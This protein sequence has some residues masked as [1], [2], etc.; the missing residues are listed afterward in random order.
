MGG[1][2][3]APE[4]ATPETTVAELL[5]LVRRMA[6][7]QPH[8]PLLVG[9]GPL[10]PLAVALNDPAARLAAS[11]EKKTEGVFGLQTLIEQSPNI[12]FACDVE[13]RIRFINYTLPMHT[14]EMAMG[15]VLYSWFEP[16]M[17][18]PVRDI[19][20]KV[21]TTG[22]RHAFEIPPPSTPAPSGTWPGSRPSGAGRRPSA[23]R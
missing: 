18:E 11:H 22:E 23:S 6:A 15:T 10:A 19:I 20:Q 9:S 3:E 4:T 13:A 8:V 21:L 16:H 14:P 5:E 12:M 17:V 2:D 1:E 7:R